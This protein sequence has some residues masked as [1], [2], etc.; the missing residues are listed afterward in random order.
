M[1]YSEDLR[2]RAVIPYSFMGVKLDELE[3]LLG[4][5][6]HSI[7]KWAG[8]VVETTESPIATRHRLPEE[9]YDHVHRYVENHSCFYSKPPSS[10]PF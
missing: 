10:Q 7:R 9:V 3:A 2:W 6:R 1:A 4:A 8:Q 5:T